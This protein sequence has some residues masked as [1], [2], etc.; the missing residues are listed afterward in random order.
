M[1]EKKFRC[2]NLANRLIKLRINSLEDKLNCITD[3]GYKCAIV[4]IDETEIIDDLFAN[5]CDY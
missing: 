5:D 4:I 3:P 1:I 2:E